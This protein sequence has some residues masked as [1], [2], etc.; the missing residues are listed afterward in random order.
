MESKTALITGVSSGIGKEVALLFAT[1]G[2]R[3]TGFGRDPKALERT[4]NLLGS[5]HTIAV[6]DLCTD[7]G[8]KE[9]CN[10]LKKTHFDV[11]INNAGFGVYGSFEQLS[12]ESQLSMLTLNNKA[13]VTLSHTYLQKATKGDALINIGSIAGEL[14]YPVSP[15]YGA[16]KA[17]VISFSESLWYTQK[18]R[19]IY[20][21]C[22]NPGAT[23]TQFHRRAG[24]GDFHSAS[25]ILQAPEEVAKVIYQAVMDRN[26]PVI[27][28]GY[29]NTLLAQSKRVLPRK[30]KVSI[31]GW[32][33]RQN[34]AM[35]KQ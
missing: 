35:R 7:I 11:L 20:V 14:S 16:T 4:Q 26:D 3:I 19:G 10:F 32:Y 12:L 9:V 8:L 27:A 22:I 21:C 25:G 23:N 2:Y 5:G 1:K 24:A 31:M 33:N 30:L 13:L 15:V 17:F 28:S 18:K 29:K 34:P 6:A